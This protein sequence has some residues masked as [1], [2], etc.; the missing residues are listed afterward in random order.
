MTPLSWQ[1]CSMC[2]PIHMNS[3]LFW[4]HSTCLAPLLST[5]RCRAIA[6]IPWPL[7]PAPVTKKDARSIPLLMSGLP[8]SRQSSPPAG[9]GMGSMRSLMPESSLMYI[10]I[11]W[12]GMPWHQLTGWW[13]RKCARRQRCRHNC[14]QYLDLSSTSLEID[15]TPTQLNSFALFEQTEQ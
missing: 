11:I 10:L 3:T 12:N 8:S 15:Q 13:Q 7:H 2:K 9:I 6:T 4:G 1:M 14:H 5:V